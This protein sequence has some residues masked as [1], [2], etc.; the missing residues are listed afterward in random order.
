MES[1]GEKI[2]RKILE[3]EGI[4]FK[5][6]YSFPT[7][8]SFKNKPLRFDFAIFENNNV[9]ALIEYQGEQHYRFIEHF[10][11]NKAKWEYSRAMDYLKC[12]FSLMSHIPLYCIPYTELN[13]LKT[14][15]DIFN[16][17]FLIRTK[18]DMYKKRD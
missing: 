14:I 4:F 8:K 6:E 3:R 1:N 11:K 15:E 10:S 12:R 18:W 2:I 5:Q 7:L 16:E 13:N 9:I 17:K